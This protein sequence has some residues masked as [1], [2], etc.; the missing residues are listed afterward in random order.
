V[1]RSEDSASVNPMWSDAVATGV[2]QDHSALA[3]P[4]ARVCTTATQ[5]FV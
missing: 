4:D 5:K 3:R 2:L 1:R